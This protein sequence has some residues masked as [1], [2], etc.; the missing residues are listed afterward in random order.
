MPPE[1]DGAVIRPPVSSTPTFQRFRFESCRLK[2]TAGALPG[3]EGTGPMPNGQIGQNSVEG[4][5]LGSQ[6]VDTENG[7]LTS[8][9]VENKTRFSVPNGTGKADSLMWLA[10]GVGIARYTQDASVGNTRALLVLKL[11]S[12]SLKK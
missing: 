1:F 5:I 6:E 12:H 7:R 10:P 3:K 11:K 8:I 2:V 4:E 9:A